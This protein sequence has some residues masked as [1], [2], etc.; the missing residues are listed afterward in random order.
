MTR[1]II[2]G[3]QGRMGKALIDGP[4]PAIPASP[5]DHVGVQ[6]LKSGLAGKAVKTVNRTTLTAV[7]S[8]R[9]GAIN[10]ASFKT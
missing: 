9:S 1:V 10:L 7:H 5:I 4:A 8:K 6:R 3:S 2:I